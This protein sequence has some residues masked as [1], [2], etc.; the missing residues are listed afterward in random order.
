MGYADLA[1]AV[2][3][4]RRAD[5]ETCFLEDSPGDGLR[6]IFQGMSPPDGACGDKFSKRAVWTTGS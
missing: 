2:G 3:S 6:N 1:R 4:A 5:R